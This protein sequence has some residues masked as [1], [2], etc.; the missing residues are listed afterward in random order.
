M[1]HFKDVN[2]VLKLEHHVVVCPISFAVLTVLEE[3]KKWRLVWGKWS[4]VRAS[5]NLDGCLRIRISALIFLMSP[6]SRHSKAEI[7]E[8]ILYPWG[9]GGRSP[10]GPTHIFVAIRKNCL[11]IALS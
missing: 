6:C 8:Q 7:M 2:N 9:Q 1:H 5:K 4:F 3:E 11:K 10:L